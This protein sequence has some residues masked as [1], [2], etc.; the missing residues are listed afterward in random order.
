[1]FPEVSAR[2]GQNKMYDVLCGT[3]PLEDQWHQQRVSLIDENAIF[4]P[5]GSGGHGDEADSMAFFHTSKFRP[6]KG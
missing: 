4:R 3:F 2:L 5:A 1:M 6:I